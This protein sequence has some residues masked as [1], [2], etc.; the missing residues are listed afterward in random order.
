MQSW[1]ATE[2]WNVNW[3]CV[4]VNGDS[5]S[6]STSVE[7]SNKYRMSHVING[8]ISNRRDLP[9][10]GQ[11][12]CQGLII[13]D[14]NGDF[15]SRKSKALLR[16]GEVAWEDVERKLF[17]LGAYNGDKTEEDF[18][19]PAKPKLRF[20][21]G[22]RVLARVGVTEW[23]PG[24]I[25]QCWFQTMRYGEVPYQIRLDDGRLI[26]A[27]SDSPEV[28]RAGEDEQLT[29]ELSVPTVGV[30]EMDHEH[31]DCIRCL[32]GLAET[33]TKASL[34][35]LLETWEE[36]FEHEESV[37]EKTGF[38]NH[39]TEMSGTRSHCID[40]ERILSMARDEL[41]RLPKDDK[42]SAE[43][44]RSLADAF[45]QHAVNYDSAYAG[46]IPQDAS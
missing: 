21:V 7:M 39:G 17:A 22:S 23:A 16:V 38:G 41:A 20:R 14:E 12:G 37:F 32:S 46:K 3:I 28:V 25:T 40:H 1:A 10:F 5:T 6:R 11:L 45:E 44:I 27:P 42:V 26:F 15:V 19:E 30:D 43:F 29:I 33:R 18:A 2:D 8:F 34:A 36:H 9:R 4:C 13:V 24:S 31:D 35:V